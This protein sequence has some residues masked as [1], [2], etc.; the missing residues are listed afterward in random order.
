MCVSVLKTL[1]SYAIKV[2]RRPIVVN[3]DPRRALESVT[4]VPGTIGAAPIAAPDASSSFMHP[5]LLDSFTTSNTSTSY[6][7]NYF[8]SA[9]TPANN[10]AFFTLLTNKLGLRLGERHAQL[11][12]PA[13]LAEFS[14]GVLCLGAPSN[15]VEV[16]E[17]TVAALSINVVLVMGSDRL[18]A[19]MNKKYKATG[20]TV[21]K[22]P[23]SGGVVKKDD[24]DRSGLQAKLV[25]S[26]FRPLPAS[27]PLTTVTLNI[28]T[29]N[30]YRLSS[31]AVSTAMLPV[32]QKQ[33]SSCVHLT[34][35]DA[36][37]EN[38]IVA[39]CHPSNVN[40]FVGGD[41]SALFAGGV[42]GFLAVERVDEEAETVVVVS[43]VRGELPSKTFLCCEE[44]AFSKV[45][46]RDVVQ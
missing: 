45:M 39:V 26:Y 11:S 30:F 41:E 40:K 34:K 2:G 36:P 28:S 13:V 9:P 18:Y 4:P 21:V 22:L 17:H 16:H 24:A 43:P 38:S 35:I 29:C 12:S 46:V 25:R 37:P 42:A 7:L 3:L 5:T 6:S 8:F 20:V 27:P 15:K 44:S 33:V 23:V 14:S 10:P 19:Q 1:S 31:V 32:G